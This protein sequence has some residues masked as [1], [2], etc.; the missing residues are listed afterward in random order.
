MKL[1]LF[2]LTNKAKILG[3]VILSIF[4]P[5]MDGRTLELREELYIIPGMNIPILLGKDV[6]VNYQ[7]LVHGTAQETTVSILQ[8]GET[9]VMPASSMPCLDMGFVVQPAHHKKVCN[10]EAY[11]ATAHVQSFNVAEGTPGNLDKLPTDCLVRAS[12]DIHI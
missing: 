8:P 12:Q 3:Y 5:M 9:F 11:L 7:I 10:W 2:E 6:Q 4:I 1:K